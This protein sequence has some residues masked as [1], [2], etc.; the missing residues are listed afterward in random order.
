MLA[1]QG[2]RTSIAKKPFFGDLSGGSRPLLSPSGYAQDM[3]PYLILSGLYLK[4][5]PRTMLLFILLLE[6]FIGHAVVTRFKL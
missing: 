6:P 4:F 5:V 2:I 3:L 1:F